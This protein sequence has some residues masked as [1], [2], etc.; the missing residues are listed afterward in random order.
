[1]QVRFFSG[2][3]GYRGL[4]RRAY[5]M[6]PRMLVEIAGSSAM[7]QRPT[8]TDRRPTTNDSP[9][10]HRCWLRRL[11][12]VPRHGARKAF[13]ELHHRLVTHQLSGQ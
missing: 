7:P 8:T 3:Q 12:A 13:L 9:L 6:L 1:M 4:R 11:R 10:A 5:A 2:S